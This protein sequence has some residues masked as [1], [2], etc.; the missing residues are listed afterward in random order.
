M[1]PTPARP[2]VVPIPWPLARAFLLSAWST[3]WKCPADSDRI[4]PCGSV[5]RH[6]ECALAPIGALRHVSRSETSQR[7]EHIPRVESTNR[8]DNW[9]DLQVDPVAVLLRFQA[10]QQEHQ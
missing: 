9:S 3:S 6:L 2:E 1:A 8:L 4:T 10:A 7:S 5:V